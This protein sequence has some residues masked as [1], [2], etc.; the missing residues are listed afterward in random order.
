MAALTSKTC[1]LFDRAQLEKNDQ[2]WLP[3][4][5]LKL[6][7]QVE[8]AVKPAVNASPSAPLFAP[9]AC[10]VIVGS[11]PF[12]RYFMRVHKGNTPGAYY[13]DERF[14]CSQYMH[15][16]PAEWLLNEQHV[17]VPY[18]QLIRR[19]EWFFDLFQ[20]E[21]LF[22]RPDSGAKTFTGLPIKRDQAAQEFSAL[23]QLT[24]VPVETLT[25]VSRGV[26]VEAEYRFV[27]VNRKVV[28]GSRYMVSGEI[29]ISTEVDSACQALAQQVAS[30]AYQ[31]DI[32]YTC[33]VAISN[34]RPKVVELNAFSTSGLYACDIKAVYHAIIE[35]AWLEHTLE[36]SLG[37]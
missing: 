6:G 1:F 18:A 26:L 3:E 22:I 30:H 37:G 25:L 2:L 27:I 31:V 23:R 12:T 4:W 14:R 28:A 19:P 35:A 24:N 10:L 11:I 9:D 5:L 16:L 15:Q 36:I 13:D 34:G 33:D 29:D 17:F 32:A 8:V 20:S 21:T 7:H